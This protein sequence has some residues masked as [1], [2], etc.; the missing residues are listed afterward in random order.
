MHHNGRDVLLA[1]TL[2]VS[3]L[4]VRPG[5]ARTIVCPDCGTWRFLRRNMIFPHRAA[6]DRSRCPGSG[7]RV[8]IDLPLASLVAPS[9][10]QQAEQAQAGLRRAARVQLKPSAPVPPP[11]FKV[12]ASTV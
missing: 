8:R 9:A 3:N 11:V 1:S 2:P 10:R 7:Q 4:E 5:E 12:K 6:D